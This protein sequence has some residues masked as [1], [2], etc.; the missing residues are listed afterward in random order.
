MPGA[1]FLVALLVPCGAFGGS[2][3]R[4]VHVWFMASRTRRELV[5]GVAPSW[6]RGGVSVVPSGAIWGPLRVAVLAERW[7]H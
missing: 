5:R 2:W 3:G 7:S 4:P 6:G 1:G